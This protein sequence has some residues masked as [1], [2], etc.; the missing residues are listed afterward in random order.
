MLRVGRNSNGVV[1]ALIWGGLSSMDP[2]ILTR[3]RLLASS[4]EHRHC[5]SATSL[6]TRTSKPLQS[7]WQPTPVV[8]SV[9]T[10][11]HGGLH[12]L[13]VHTTPRLRPRAFPNSIIIFVITC[14]FFNYF[15]QSLFI[16]SMLG[17]GRNSTGVGLT[18][19]W[20]NLGSKGLGRAVMAW[21]TATDDKMIK[22]ASKRLTKSFLKTQTRG[23]KFLC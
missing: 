2:A 20:V 23:P 5:P 16:V 15:I 4:Y 11:P 3:G 22:R 8:I 12:Q 1:L 10:R 18:L 17:V 9:A 14:I 19:T 21:G 13:L 6:P 7:P